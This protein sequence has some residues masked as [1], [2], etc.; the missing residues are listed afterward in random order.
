MQLCNDHYINIAERS[1]GFKPE[2]LEFDFGSCNKNGV[3][4]SILDKYRNHPSIAKIHKNRNFQSSST[5]IPF[6]IWGS[7]ITPKEINTILNSLN[8]KKAPG[9]GK[10]PTKIVKF[11]CGISTESLS[12]T[13]NNS[14][15]TSIFPNNAKIVIVVPV[16]KKSN[17]KYAI[18]NS[19]PVS[20]LNCFSKVYE[21]F[22][23]NKVLKYMN[24]HLRP[25]ISAYQKNYNTQ[26]VML[27]LLEEWR[28]HLDKTRQW[29]DY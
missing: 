27:R 2:K 6:S 17:D 28:E 20:I 18:C 15:S 13:I 21:N 9:I 7:K 1:Y 8:S 26:H 10:I 4:S 29:D 16:G 11:Q 5:L 3:L 23:K 25:F 12:I 14:I 19:R 24:V 22:I